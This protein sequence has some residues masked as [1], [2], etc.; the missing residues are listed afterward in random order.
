MG[1]S[2]GDLESYPYFHAIANLILDKKVDVDVVLLTYIFENNGE[3]KTKPSQNSIRDLRAFGIEPDII[4]CRSKKKILER[5]LNKLSSTTRIP[6]ENIFPLEDVK[7]LYNI[8]K[9][10]R[11]VV[12]RVGLLNNYEGVD[13]IFPLYLEDT[14]S[15]PINID[16]VGKYGDDT[17]AYLSVVESIKHAS[18]AY[19]RTANIRI[20]SNM[21]GLRDNVQ[22]VVIPGG[23]GNRGLEDKLEVIKHCRENDIPLFG[24]CLGMQLMFIDLLISRVLPDKPM[25]LGEHKCSDGKYHIFRHRYKCD[26]ELFEKLCNTGSVVATH[27]GD[28]FGY[29]TGLELL[30]NKFFGGVQYHPEYESNINEPNTDFMN[31]VSACL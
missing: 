8:P 30:S 21:S 27:F 17:D 4:I 12:D 16:I 14:D 1:G 18:I 26:L 6:K 31:F 23:F 15:E 7:N 24:I 2:V 25:V 11:C 10:L 19:G 22:G 29:P 5:T 13:R 28:S 20:I 3:Q 9:R